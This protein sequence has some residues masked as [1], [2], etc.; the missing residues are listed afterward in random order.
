MR[1]QRAS[2]LARRH[3]RGDVPF[4]IDTRRDRPKHRAE[5]V[6]ER[7]SGFDIVMPDPDRVSPAAPVLHNAVNRRQTKPGAFADVFGGEE[8]LKYVRQ[9]LRGYAG[10]GIGHAQANEVTGAGLRM[11]LG[12][13]GIEVGG[14]GARESWPPLGMAS[15]ALTARLTSTCSS[16][17]RRPGR[18]GGEP[19]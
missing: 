12:G 6:M 5:I 7:K 15:R 16:M 10:A 8:R 19:A 13:S 9:V 3:N 14:L 11:S 4:A 18:R 2:T 1:S 17:P